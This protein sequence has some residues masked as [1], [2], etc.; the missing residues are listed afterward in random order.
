MRLYVI[1]HGESE[2]NVK[3]FWTGWYDAP[4]TERGREEAKGL[5]HLLS[6]VSFD[7]IYAS[8]LSR[9]I[10]T[11]KSAIPDCQPETTPLLREINLGLLANKPLSFLDAAKK[12]EIVK[13]G[14]V[15]FGGESN[16]EF[17]ERVSAFMKEMEASSHQ[18]VAA[19]CHAGWLR[20]ALNYVLDTELIRTRVHCGNCAV[21]VFEY[22]NGIW[23]LYSFINL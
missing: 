20:R 18:T 4:L 11:A 10:E 3:G 21:G 9:A 6:S 14:Y 13:N 2:N 19:F 17:Q 22:E 12:A 8:D 16:E 15:A 1:R 5:R 23:R 7:K